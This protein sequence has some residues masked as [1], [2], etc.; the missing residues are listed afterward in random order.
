MYFV[1]LF[2]LDNNNKNNNIIEWF[3]DSICSMAFLLSSLK[4][5]AFYLLVSLNYEL[6][7]FGSYGNMLLKS[8]YIKKC[9]LHFI[10]YSTWLVKR[11]NMIQNK[12]DIFAGV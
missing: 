6:D 8:V 12:L 5:K 9:C 1:C 11:K 2:T 3:I 4:L 7:Y 10:H